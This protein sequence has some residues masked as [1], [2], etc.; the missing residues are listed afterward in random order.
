MFNRILIPTDGSDAVGPAI[1]T[2]LDVADT[3]DATL[4]VLYV[5][6]P[7]SSVVGVGEGFTGVDNLLEELEEEGRQA[8]DAIAT[9]ATDNDIDT[10]TAIQQ[11]NPRE[12]ILAYA[13]DHEIDLIVIGTRGRTGVKRTLLGSVTE[14][15]IRHADVPVLT[16]HREPD[17]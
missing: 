17:E 5:V 10:T 1:E 16:V 14:A 2:A 13:T 9:Q 7:P 8:T 4:H 6:E 11:G 12:D 15:V 3:Y